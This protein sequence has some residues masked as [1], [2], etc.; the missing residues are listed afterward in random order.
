[1]KAEEG[2]GH[3]DGVD[4]RIT[5]DVG[6][7][8]RGKEG[9]RNWGQAWP[10]KQRREARGPAPAAPLLWPASLEPGPGPRPCQHVLETLIQPV[11][12]A[13]AR[14]GGREAQRLQGQEGWSPWEL[15]R[16]SGMQEAEVA[17]SATLLC[18][19]SG[20]L[21]RGTSLQTCRLL[22]TD[23]GLCLWVGHRGHGGEPDKRM[24][25]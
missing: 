15:H 20:G 19:A 22:E 13:E 8:G 14:A 2:T 12:S 6:G 3:G 1:M 10:G 23:S 24:N 5:T 7:M 18:W 25:K 4:V 9:A 17:M 21:F 11:C 16:L